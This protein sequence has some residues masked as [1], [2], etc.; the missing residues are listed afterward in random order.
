MELW[1]HNFAEITL[2]I[3]V[4]QSE[5]NQEKLTIGDTKDVSIDEE[6][7]INFKGGT[8]TPLSPSMKFQT[9]EVIQKDGNKA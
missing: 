2:A 6:K 3:K 1:I 9:A 5:G 8:S 7:A 4:K